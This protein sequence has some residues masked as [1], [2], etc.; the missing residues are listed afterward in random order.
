MSLSLWVCRF[1]LI[2]GILIS[3]AYIEWSK[4]QRIVIEESSSWY[5]PYLFNLEYVQISEGIRSRDNMT[6]VA[7][8][9]LVATSTLILG[10]CIQLVSETEID[11]RMKI[12]MISASLAIYTIW[13]IPFYATSSKLNNLAYWRLQR[14]EEFNQFKLHR[15]FNE[16][17]ERKENVNW[18]NIR[19]LGWLIFYWLLIFISIFILLF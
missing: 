14:M 12:L 16:Q 1:I 19:R 4:K 13:L 7:G 9:I 15:F 11:I 8:T 6:M 18:I 3:V 17:L 5:D 2:A 10:A